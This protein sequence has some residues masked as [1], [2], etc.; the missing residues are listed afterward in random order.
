MPASR[1][2]RSPV[3]PVAEPGGGAPRRRRLRVRGGRLPGSGLGAS[4]P[5]LAA[6]S[7]GIGAGRDPAG[8][9]RRRARAGRVPGLPL[10]PFSFSGVPVLIA[11]G[12]KPSPEAGSAGLSGGLPVLGEGAVTG[13]RRRRRRRLRS[14]RMGRDPAASPGRASALASTLPAGALGALAS[15]AGPSAADSPEAAASVGLRRRRRRRRRGA[16]S[17]ALASGACSP[18]AFESAGAIPAA[19]GKPAVASGCSCPSVA[20]P[21]S[22]SVGSRAGPRL[23][24]PAS[25]PPTDHASVGNS[26]V[27]QKSREAR[28]QRSGCNRLTPC[29]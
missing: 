3:S 20:S 12:A 7:P 17:C 11:A 22:D 13:G 27:R 23:L 24:V 29:P 28:A 10:G 1:G 18:V 15:G 9:R 21:A 16:P 4:W 19:P 8:R 5:G 14:R 6:A 26:I 2:R 25:E